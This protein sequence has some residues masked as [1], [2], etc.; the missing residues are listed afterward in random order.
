[1][2][3]STCRSSSLAMDSFSVR[4]MF[5]YDYLHY[6]D[7]YKAVLN[8]LLLGT[9]YF[10]TTTPFL[11]MS[12]FCVYSV[13]SALFM[14]PALYTYFTRTLEIYAFEHAD[15][16]GRAIDLVIQPFVRFTSMAFFPVI[17]CAGVL[18]LLVRQ[19]LHHCPSV[20]TL[21]SSPCLV[22]FSAHRHT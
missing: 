17:I 1:M 9:V 19:D 20:V 13:A 21:S 8:S 7:C 4:H 12:G 16:A 15:G 18:Y 14:F 3:F 2:S 11:V 10:Q 6:S 22:F 5:L